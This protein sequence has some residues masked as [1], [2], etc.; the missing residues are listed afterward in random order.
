MNTHPEPARSLPVL[1]TWDVVVCGGGPAGCAAARTAALAGA[2]TLLIERDGHLGGT[3]VSSLVSVILSTNAMDFQGVWHDWARALERLGGISR[4]ARGRH[5]VCPDWICGAVHPEAVKQAWDA[6]L[7]E[8]GV[9]L[10]HHAWIGGALRD[11]AG[12]VVGVAVQTVAGRQAVLAQQV[13][14]A[15]GDAVVAADA[16]AAYDCGHAGKPWAMGVGIM[17]RMGGVPGLAGVEP[18]APQPGRGRRLPGAQECIGGMMRVL[19]VDPLDAFALTRASREGRSAIWQRIG[20]NV[21]AA[22]GATLLETPNRPGVRSSRRVR[23]LACVQDHDCMALTR[24][25]H[26]IAR[27]S[28]EVDIHPAEVPDGKAVDL[29]DPDYRE[30]FAGTRAG[31]WFDI[32]FGA[33][34]PQGVAG[35]LVA[36]RCISA[37][38]IAQSSLRI[39]QTCMALGE[40]AGLAAALCAGRGIPAAALGEAELAATLAARRTAIAPWS[41]LAGLAPG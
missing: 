30:R 6:L 29:D 11:G 17:W 25:P 32:P 31:G 37:S 23:G 4:L 38:H 7:A 39:Q 8:A 12:T 36:G 20:G 26:G 35:L 1:G 33:L 22:D 27:A 18:G 15:S 13:V 9:E 19:T 3:A 2:R 28:W 10:L 5:P 41:G 14:D 24:H 16:G 21:R 34:V 40:A